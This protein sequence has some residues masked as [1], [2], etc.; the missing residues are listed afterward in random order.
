[1]RDLSLHLLDIVENSIRAGAK[2][3]RIS[4]FKDKCRILHLTIEDDGCGMDKEMLGKVQD[5]FT[6]SRTSRKIGLGLPLLTQNARLTGKD[7]KI[8]SKVGIGTKVFAEFDTNSIDCLPLGD[9]AQTICS[10]I[11]S[12]PEKPEFYLNCGS[13][14]GEM[15]FSTVEIRQALHGVPLNEPEIIE[16][17]G[18]S[19]QEEILPIFG[20][21]VI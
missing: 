15:S 21:I 17:I 12:N 6:T 11:L 13:E 9:I 4:I 5:P 16:W 20:G 2:N 1:M 8:E 7:V 3:V 10:L 18:E 14:A 19:I